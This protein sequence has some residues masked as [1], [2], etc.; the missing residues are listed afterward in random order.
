[1]LLQVVDLNFTHVGKEQP[2]INDINLTLQAGELVVLAGATGSGKSTLLNCITGIAPEHT[3]GKLSGQVFYRRSE[4]T[5]NSIRQR[6]QFMGMMLQNVET[7]LFTDQVWDEVVFG[8]ENWNL[9]P[10][11]IQSLAQTALLEFD[12]VSQKTWTIRQL[13]AGQKQRLLLA[14]LLTRHQD[15]LLLDEPFAFLDTAGVKLLLELLQQRVAQG[16]A[17][18]LIEHRLELLQQ[19]C[20]RAYLIDNGYITPWDLSVPPSEV[21]AS[22]V[23]TNYFSGERE[24]EIVLKTQNLSWGGY[25][26]FPD[27]RVAAGEVVLLKGDNGCGKTTLLKLLSGLLKPSTGS[28]EI[29]GRDLTRCTVVQIA[30]FVGFVLQNPN[31]QLFAESVQ[32]EV[33]Q[34][35]VSSQQAEA[36]LEQLNL[37]HCQEQHPHALSQGQKRRLALGAVLVRQPRICL[38]DEIMVGQDPTSLTLMLQTLKTFTEQGGTLIFTS[39]DPGVARILNPRVVQIG[40]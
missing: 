6:S 24:S 28:L 26:A 20:D 30:R 2:T 35:D 22:P 12:L 4:I 33:T 34:P 40:N 1:M 19:L 37:N 27:L 21:S 32:A 39:H 18:L 13:S 29:L 23:P 9:P 15:I 3:G 7:Q 10:G 17:V 14:C 16:Q 36:L 31:H 8:L 5:H 38:L 25:P 11:E